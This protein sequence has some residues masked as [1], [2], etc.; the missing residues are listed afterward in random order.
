MNLKWPSNGPNRRATHTAWV[1]VRG[2]CQD[3]HLISFEAGEIYENVV[4]SV[5]H[6]LT[7]EAESTGMD[8]KGGTVHKK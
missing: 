2:Q 1:S 5:E 4:S 3:H 8:T 6:V 7:E